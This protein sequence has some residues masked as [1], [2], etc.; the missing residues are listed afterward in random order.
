MKFTI[1]TE[2]N[3][4]DLA[5]KD[6]KERYGLDDK[7]ILEKG[8]AYIIIETTVEKIVELC[9]TSQ[10]AGRILIT[11]SQGTFSNLEDLKKK[12]NSDVKE[13]IKKNMI[14][15][16]MRCECERIG[17]HD[18]N[19]VEIENIMMDLIEGKK[20][21]LKNADNQIYFQI[22]DN[23]YVCG[24][25]LLKKDLSKRHYKLF[26]HNNAIKGTTAYNML[27]FSDF[28]KEQIVIDPFSMSGVLPIEIALAKTKLPINFYDKP[29]I[30]NIL[31]F[32]E[33]KQN[34]I[35]KEIDKKVNFDIKQE[36]YSIDAS[37]TNISA[38]K[39]NAK[40][41]GVEKNIEFSKMPAEDIDLKLEPKTADLVVSRII[42]QSKHIP[43][44]KAR[45]IYK[46]F[47][48]HVKPILKPEAKIT[49]MARNTK[50]FEEEAISQ[51]YKKVQEKPIFQGKQPMNIV[52]FKNV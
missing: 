5:E 37:F 41:A 23:E 3:C 50:L 13:E 19:S 11:I 29:K 49:I 8:N 35:Q 25:D 10:L 26:N 28:K 51:G 1:I 12:L 24:I 46:E 4:A 27:L 30:K 40:I 9:Y 6:L 17:T 38:Q 48:E 18:F 7:V 52:T 45:R 16:T 20:V 43:E 47:L 42:E 32:E 2:Q 31:G 36:I 21:D 39:K 15:K 14:G 33:E 34:K 22:I 44:K